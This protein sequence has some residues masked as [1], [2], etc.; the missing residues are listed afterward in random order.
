[1]I[2]VTEAD[3]GPVRQIGIALYTKV[4]L[5]CHI[6]CTQPH[7]QLHDSLESANCGPHGEGMTYLALTSSAHSSIAPRSSSVISRTRSV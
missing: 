2:S 3:S 7:L 1:M 5:G 4:A 6:R